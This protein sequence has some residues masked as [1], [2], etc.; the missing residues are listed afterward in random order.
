MELESDF[1]SFLTEIRPTKDQRDDMK[2][3]HQTLR[4]RL[5]KDE[6]IK[7][8]H[9]SDFL[10]GSYRRATAVRPSNDQ[11]SDVDI[12]VVTKLS[13]KD[14]SPQ[15]AMDVFIPFLDS[16]YK[17]KWRQ[18]NRSFGIEL[19]YVDLDLVIT[20]APS[21]VEEGILKSAA[22]TTDDD[23]VV[24]HDWRMNEAWL[25]LDA[26]DG[27][28]NARSLIERV[29]ESAEEEP[30]PLRIPDRALEQWEDTNP[31]EQIR[32]T[33]DKNASTNGHFVNVV[34]AIKWWRLENYEEPE[35]PKGYPLE[36]LIGECC[37]DSI[38][39]VAE[40]I[41]Q[42]LENI[43]LQYGGLIDEGE[44]PFLPDYGVPSHDVFEKVTVEEF[45][46]FYGQ[47][48]EGALLA[49]RALDSQDRDESN[50]LWQELLGGKFPDPPKNRTKGEGYTLPNQSAVPGSGRFA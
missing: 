24:A 33:R 50:K 2:T 28:D 30:Q 39:S 26:R 27:N 21:E 49:R 5:N 35:H 1:R 16:Y 42:T 7:K 36:R 18:Q 40:G 31:L 11:R 48:K 8:I 3:G 4:E 46:A 41:T 19:S 25:A 9:V 38:E 12:V 15:K 17:G 32:W 13:E 43:V 23:I 37:P 6:T 44:K 10:Q 34:K 20:A 45:K 29:K 22:V 14:Y 47:A